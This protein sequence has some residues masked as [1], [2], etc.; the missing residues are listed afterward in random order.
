MS[1]ELGLADLAGADAT[2]R[3]T[4][5]A[6]LTKIGTLKQKSGAHRHAPAPRGR[7]KL[8]LLLPTYYPCP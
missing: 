1:P 3:P 6:L 5:L 7:Y 4:W 8:K 2:L